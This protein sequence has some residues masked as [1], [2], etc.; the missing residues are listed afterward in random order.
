MCGIAGWIHW[1][2]DL[3]DAGIVMEKM[4]ATLVP[5]GPDASGYWLSRHAAFAHRRLI[6]VD[7]AGGG[8]PMIRQK[9]NHHYVLVYNG[10]LYNTEELRS[11]LLARGYTFLGHSDTE[12]LL[13]AYMEWGPACVEKLNGIFAFAVWDSERQLLFLA[14]DRLGVKPL[15]FCR[16]PHS[17]IFASELKAILAHPEIEPKIDA[18]GLAEIFVMGPSRTPGHGVFKGIEELK[19]GYCL[20]FN[21]SGLHMSRYWALESRPHTDDFATTARKIRELLEDAVVR[22]LVADVPVC[23]LLSGGLDSSTITAFAAREYQRRGLPPLR[24]FSI[25]YEGN[26]RHFQRNL[27]QPE[28]DTPFVKLVSDYYGTSHRNITVTTNQLAE[29]LI[30]AMQARDLPGMADIDSSLL[31]F[32]QEIKKEATVALS[33]ECADEVF[34]GYPW[35]HQPEALSSSTF[36]WMRR[37]PEKLKYFSSELVDYIKPEE[38][39]TRRYLETLDEVPRLEGESSFENRI[40]EIFYL[41]IQWFM[42]TLLDRKDRMSM[43][44]GLEVRVPF[45]DHRLVEYLW[46]IP[47]SMKNYG[48]QPKGIMRLALQDVLPPE[49]LNRRKTPYPKTHN[50]AYSQ[51]VRRLLKEVI[52]DPSSPLLPFLNGKKLLADL[53][54]DED[55]FDVPWFGQLMTGPQFLAYLLQT[56]AWFRHYRVQVL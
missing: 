17:L 10:E 15:F 40:R 21:R 2:R 5:R 6:V 43:A 25:D 53:E 22:Q 27:F 42:T 9:G 24:T 46:N 11:Q 30:P 29:A 34:G 3:R 36:P 45:A 35:F 56:D 4:A 47:W 1:Q 41:T 31:L 28:A 23:T 33:G 50:P 55:F 54:G 52:T 13:T 38:Y 18:E 49:V 51:A 7:P 16:R 19:P 39:L 8:Q 32:C 20:T 26:E 37:L 14:R 44:C 12:V 48:G